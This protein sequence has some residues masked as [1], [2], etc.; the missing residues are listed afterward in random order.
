[1]LGCIL[2]SFQVLLGNLNSNNSIDRVE[3]VLDIITQSIVTSKM[4]KNTNELLKEN[5]PAFFFFWTYQWRVYSCY[6]KGRKNMPVCSTWLHRWTAS[7]SQVSAECC[8]SSSDWHTSSGKNLAKLTKALLWRGMVNKLCGI[9]KPSY[10]PQELEQRL[11]M[12]PTPSITHGVR[13]ALPR[14]QQWGGKPCLSR[15]VIVL[16]PW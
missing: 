8:S 9:A 5:L 10:E 4:H 2:I 16:L 15:W 12:L 14:E 6:M 7:E 13:A 3:V 1:M 11:L